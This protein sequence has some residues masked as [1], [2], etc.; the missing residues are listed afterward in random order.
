[1]HPNV[2]RTLFPIAKIYRQCN[3]PL[4]DEWIKTVCYTYPHMHIHTHT[5]THKWNISH[6]KI[7][8]FFL[9]ATWIDLDDTI[10]SDINHAEKNKYYLILLIYRIKTNN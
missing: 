5:H 3:C 10:L 8:F 6:K 4:I 2:H 1:M 7:M 9:F